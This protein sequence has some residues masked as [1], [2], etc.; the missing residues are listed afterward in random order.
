MRAILPWFK[1][2]CWNW[3]QSKL[4]VRYKYLFQIFP[5]FSQ[6]PYLILYKGFQINLIID[7]NRKVALYPDSQSSS[8][9]LSMLLLRFEG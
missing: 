3:N 6:F 7:F 2:G 1:K 5:F 4:C 8:S 9:T